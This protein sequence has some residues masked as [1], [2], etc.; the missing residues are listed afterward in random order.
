MNSA[1]WPTRWRFY[2]DPPLALTW[3]HDSTHFCVSGPDAEADWSIAVPRGESGPE[4]LFEWA[5]DVEGLLWGAG[6]CMVVVK[7]RGGRG[8]E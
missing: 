6:W 2:N 1:Q 5:S 8:G 7:V 4:G 3:P